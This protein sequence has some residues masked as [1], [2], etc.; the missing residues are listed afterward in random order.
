M[1]T[2]TITPAPESSLPLPS[3]PHSTLGVLCTTTWYADP[4]ITYTGDNE[5]PD[6]E[7]MCAYLLDYIPPNQVIV[8]LN[9]KT[10]NK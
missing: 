10:G 5:P 7:Y 3:P 9:A 6:M 2:G 8:T 4:F 1:A